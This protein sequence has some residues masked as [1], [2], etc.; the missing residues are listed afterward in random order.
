MDTRAFKDAVLQLALR[1]M[2]ILPANEM[3]AVVQALRRNQDDVDK[4]V[5][6]AMEALSKSSNLIAGLED[7]LKTR[8]AKLKELQAE[9]ARISNL[10]SLTKE[11]GKAVA[12]SLAQVLG[13]TQGK[14]RLVSFGINIFAGLILFVLGVF[15]SEWVKALPSKF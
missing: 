6:E 11:Q 7:T 10:A 4:Q 1:M 2:P 5:S 14:E 13:Q 9:Y 8:E 12:E 3:F 15:A